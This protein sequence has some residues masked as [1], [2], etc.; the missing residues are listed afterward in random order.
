MAIL[1]DPHSSHPEQQ[2]VLLVQ[3]SWKEMWPRRR[4]CDIVESYTR[5]VQTVILH[6]KQSCT[7]AIYCCSVASWL[8]DPPIS[9]T[10]IKGKVNS[11]HLTMQKQN[12]EIHGINLVACPVKDCL[13]RR[14]VWAMP[15]AWRVKTSVVLCLHCCGTDAAH[16]QVY[17]Y[18]Q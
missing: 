14:F 18:I 13:F 17:L 16:K 2:K 3:V 8:N 7:H 1:E 11:F 10:R 9:A 6:L 5:A 12:A 15:H 4:T